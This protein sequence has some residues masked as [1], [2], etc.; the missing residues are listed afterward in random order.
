[1][2]RRDVA[3][4]RE[5]PAQGFSPEEVAVQKLDS[6]FDRSQ[7]LWS[8]GYPFTAVDF[9]SYGACWEKGLPPLN[10]AEASNSLC[11]VEDRG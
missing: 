9:C 11:C 8:E 7:S 1:M 6:G 4:H 3:S 5:F 10:T 2:A